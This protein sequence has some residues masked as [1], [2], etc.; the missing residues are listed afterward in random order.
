MAAQAI[1]ALYRITF[2]AFGT[3]GLSGVL[4]LRS[5]SSGTSG[6]CVK[7]NATLKRKHIKAFAEISHNCW[8]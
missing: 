7:R 8:C 3:L 2:L 4:S 1:S 5:G 6:E